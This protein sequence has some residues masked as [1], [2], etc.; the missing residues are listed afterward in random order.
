MR[1]NW[2]SQGRDMVERQLYGRGIRDR[3]V[4]DAM[5][6]LPRELFIPEDQRLRAYADTPVPIGFDQTISQPYMTALMCESLR[7]RGGEVVLD[8]GTG[9]GY[10]AAVLGR[11]SKRVYSIE[12]ICALADQARRNLDA[13]GVRNVEVICGDG[14]KGYS[15]GMPYDAISVAAAAPEV[16]ASLIEQL[17]DPRRLVI[18]I[19]SRQDQQL[20]VITKS[21]GLIRSYAPTMCVF[22]PLRGEEGFH[23]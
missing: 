13:A 18:P 1:R 11:L 9:S 19:G 15:E 8:V 16:P 17:R 2:T 20:T 12:I 21:A 4:L 7:L 23:E 3:R 22:V 6:D 10:H 14:T 5:R